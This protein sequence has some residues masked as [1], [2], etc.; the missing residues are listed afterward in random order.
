MGLRYGSSPH[1]RG[2][3]QIVCRC[4]LDK[5]FIPACAGNTTTSLKQPSTLAVHPRMRGEHMLSIPY[6]NQCSGSSPHARGTRAEV[7][8]DDV[9][10]AVH[11][12]M[13]GEH[14]QRM[15]LE[16]CRTGSSP[17]ARGT[18]NGKIIKDT[19]KRFIPACAG[20]TSRSIYPSCNR[21][22]HPRMRGEH[23]QRSTISAFW[24]GS[25]PHARGTPAYQG[26]IRVH[27]RFIP[28]CAGNTVRAMCT[29]MCTAVHPRM[30]GEHPP[31]VGSR[32]TLFGSSPHARGTHRV[33]Q[34]VA[35]DH[36]FIPACAGN[37]GRPGLR[38]AGASVHP[39]MRGEHVF[40]SGSAQQL[41]GSSP[42]A[43]GTLVAT[44]AKMGV[45][46]FIPACA[47]NTPLPFSLLFSLPV[48]P[49][50]RGEH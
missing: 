30:R 37:T 2:T 3:H 35:V 19:V 7:L 4:T 47:G 20:N 9:S 1:A 15:K 50:M 33:S 27:L 31:A 17:H 21:Q 13:R 43:R 26:I 29:T 8:V 42:H 25:S 12:R 34:C 18:H 22:V 23:L 45:A 5:R 16:M 11:P 48:H 44:T 46:W 28:A 41:P 40:S 36:R 39:R 10:H 6:G 14:E 49:R 24:A 38:A 32:F